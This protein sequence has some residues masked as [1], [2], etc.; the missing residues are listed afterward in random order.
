MTFELR[1]KLG[2]YARAAVASRSLNF[3]G[4]PLVPKSSASPFCRAGYNT[5]VLWIKQLELPTAE[6]IFDVGANHGDFARAAS[7]CH[8]AAH[9]WLFEPLPDLWPGLHHLAARQTNWSVLGIALGNAT[10]QH[11]L[12][13]AD[14][15]SIGSLLGFSDE[16]RRANPG[17]GEHRTIECT[18]ET[19]DDFCV[20]EGIASIDLLKIDV[21]GFE[22]EV[23]EGGRS[24]LRQTKALIIEVSLIRR[25]GG[26][27]D[28]LGRLISLLN[29]QG[30][31]VVD[32]I[33]SLFRPEEPWKPLEFNVLARR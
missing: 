30:F 9:V 16:Y 2:L 12:Q 14:D 13:V 1:K 4:L 3:P 7:H 11:L 15:D 31:S 17:S 10:G 28:A 27:P 18:V 19:L 33:P 24:M 25:A 23:L 21:E 29:A 22:F 20:R 6:T 32:V 5:F 8:A 26:T